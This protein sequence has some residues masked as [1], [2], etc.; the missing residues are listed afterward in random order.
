MQLYGLTMEDNEDLA[1]LINRLKSIST[2]LVYIQAPVPDEDKIAVLLK[3]LPSS[4]SQIVTVLK[5]KEP[6]PSL[7]RVINS[8]QEEEKKVGPNKQPNQ[9]AYVIS[10]STKKCDNCGKTNHSSKDCFLL[11]TCPHC[12]KKG[13]SPNRCFF[14]NNPKVETKTNLALKGKEETNLIMEDS[15]DEILFT[16]SPK[17]YKKDKDK[18][19]NLNIKS[20]D[21]DHK[22][23]DLKGKAKAIED[24][25]N[26][27]FEDPLSSDSDIL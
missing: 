5:E 18:A 20:I 6:I 19:I 4:Y 9:A 15:G 24:E 11:K 2:Q 27:F 23:M 8:L 12:G 3:A 26:Y 10:K 1:S 7:E 22:A 13:H 16:Y 17:G 25:N 14:K 21:K